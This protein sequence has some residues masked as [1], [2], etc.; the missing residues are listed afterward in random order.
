MSINED[1][2]YGKVKWYKP[3]RG[4]GYIIGY[5]EE[6]YFFRSS[7]NFLANDEVLF[8]PVEREET[9]VAIRVEKK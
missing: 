3:E 6:T 7:E 5:D 8:E 2:M 9:L 1:R 4:Y